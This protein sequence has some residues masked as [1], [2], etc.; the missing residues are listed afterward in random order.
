MPGAK[1]SPP[2]AEGQTGD[3]KPSAKGP[4][5]EVVQESRGRCMGYSQA[6]RVLV[7]DILALGHLCFGMSGDR[8]VQHSDPFCMGRGSE[9]DLLQMSISFESIVNK[10]PC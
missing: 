4:L 10:F 9:A 8:E 5:G 2:S 6:L 1:L 3:G 7:W